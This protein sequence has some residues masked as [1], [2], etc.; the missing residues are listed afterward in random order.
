MGTSSAAD[1]LAKVRALDPELADELEKAL[2]DDV[3]AFMKQLGDGEGNAVA[4]GR[5][6]G[7]A[8][9]DR[10][11]LPGKYSLCTDF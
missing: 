1:L 3:E 4:M 2:Q 11:M 10:P 6:L 5:W 7:T 8:C 9:K